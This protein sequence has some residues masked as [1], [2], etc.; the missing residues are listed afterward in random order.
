LKTNFDANKSAY[1]TG[2]ENVVGEKE[3]FIGKLRKDL[4]GKDIKIH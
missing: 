2:M 3:D 4:A 1:N